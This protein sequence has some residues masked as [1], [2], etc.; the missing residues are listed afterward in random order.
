M[1]IGLFLLS[2]FLNTLWNALGSRKNHN[3]LLG[4]FCFLTILPKALNI[5]NADGENTL[6]ILPTY[7][8]NLWFITYYFIGCYIKTYRPTVKARFGIPAAILIAVCYALV[9]RAT[10]GGGRFS[11]GFTIT[12]YSAGTAA[13]TILLFLSV[14]QAECSLR[15]VT[16]A[17]RFISGITLEMYLISCVFDQQIYPYQRGKYPVSDYWWRGLISTGLVFI[18]SMVSGFFPGAD[19]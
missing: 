2:P 6:N 18:L 1:Y 12:Y 7:W 4:I 13:I 8:V 9:N 16:E 19:H 5:V 14:Y 3:F 10:G 11:D 15:P 17:A